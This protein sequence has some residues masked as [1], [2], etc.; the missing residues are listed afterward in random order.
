MFSKNKSHA[1]DV[2]QWVKCL[3]IAGFYIDLPVPAWLLCFLKCAWETV[4][5]HASFQTP[6]IQDGARKAWLLSGPAP[7]I[8]TVGKNSNW[9]IFFS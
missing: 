3:L 4:E 8:I 5:D 7:D 2:T 9:K 1:G 6:A